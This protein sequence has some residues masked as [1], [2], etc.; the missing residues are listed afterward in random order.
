[1]EVEGEWQDALEGALGTDDGL[2]SPCHR[3]LADDQLRAH[4]GTIL[5]ADVPASPTT[6]DGEPFGERLEHP[7]LATLSA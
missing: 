6:P 3:E 5:N 2:E 7:L 1:M 4:A